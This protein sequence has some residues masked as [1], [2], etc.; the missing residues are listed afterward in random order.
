[1]LA[2]SGGDEWLDDASD[3][4]EREAEVRA[5]VRVRDPNVL[6]SG[7]A[8]GR[9]GQHAHPGIMEQLLGQRG[10]G[11]ARAGDVRECIESPGR[12]QAADTRNLIESVDNEVASSAELDDHRVDVVLLAAQRLGGPDL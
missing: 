2:L 6:G 5:R 1:M 9:P 12:S 8:E 3:A 11:Q 10:A 7:L 4:I